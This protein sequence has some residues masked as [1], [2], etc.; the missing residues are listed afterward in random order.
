MTSL[1][2]A[3]LPQPGVPQAQPVRLQGDGCIALVDIDLLDADG[4]PTMRGHAVCLRRS[5]KVAEPINSGDAGAAG[6]E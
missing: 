6:A 2:D 5:A 1:S 4:S 3:L